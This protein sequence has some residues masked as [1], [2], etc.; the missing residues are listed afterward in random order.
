MVATVAVMANRYKLMHPRYKTRYYAS[1]MGVYERAVG[2]IYDDEE[3]EE[4]THNYGYRDGL[5]I[6]ERRG[7][8][9]RFDHVNTNAAWDEVA[10]AKD[11][12]GLDR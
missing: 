10:N 6:W 3:L 8:G 11:C 7:D 9:W 5:G 1:F 4:A 12:P 2:M